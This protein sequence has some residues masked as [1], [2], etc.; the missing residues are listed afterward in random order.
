MA[1][2]NDSHIDW[3]GSEL[4]TP[5]AK[6]DYNRKLF[7]EVSLTYDK[8]TPWLSFFRDKAWKKKL[9]S[10]VGKADPRVVV[11]IACGTG[12]ITLLLHNRW[13]MCKIW[14]TDLTREMITQAPSAPGV[15]YC[16]ADMQ[17]LG[18][19]TA[20]CDIV[21]GGYALRNAPDLQQTLREVY[22]VLKPG[23]FG[24]FLDFSHSSNWFIALGQYFILKVWGS[25]FGLVFHRNAAVYGYL[26]DSHRKF[27]A[28]VHLRTLCGQE[29]IP[30]IIE[31]RCMMGLLRIWILCKQ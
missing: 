17:K 21:T 31:K 2:Q 30:V 12:D 9:V 26:A 22:R 14:G 29:K 16:L 3:V 18:I 25:I 23:G 19:A 27:P 4:D 7:V 13:P 24:A 15:T 10:L 8:A 6:R 1:S 20:S 5:L 28:T 11:D